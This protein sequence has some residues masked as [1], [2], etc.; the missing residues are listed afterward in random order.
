MPARRLVLY[1]TMRIGAWLPIAFSAGLL[2]ACSLDVGGLQAAP[3]AGGPSGDGGTRADATSTGHPDLPVDGGLRDSGSGADVPGPGAV[4]SDATALPDAVTSQE[5]GLDVSPPPDSDAAPSVDAGTPPA[6]GSAPAGDAAPCGP[7]P[8]PGGPSCVHVPPGWTLVAF[9]SSQ[10]TACPADF[11]AGTTDLVEGPTAAAGACS[12]GACTVTAQPTCASGSVA[13]HYDYTTGTGAGTCSLPASPGTGPLSNSPPGSCG[14]DLYQ[15]SYASFDIAYTAPPASGGACTA[16]GVATG[17]GVTYAAQDR[18]CAA[19]AALA[20]SCG[21]G[22]CS[23]GVA[24]PFKACIMNAG[25]VACPPGPMSARHLV[26]SGATVS[27]SACSTC[28][29]AATCSG[30]VTLYTDPKCKSG[31]FAVPADG[32]CYPIYRQ[33]AS[34]N[35][36]TYDGG[37]PQ[38]VTCQATGGSTAQGVTLTNEATVC[39]AP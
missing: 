26:G 30:A 7:G 3:D 2:A 34:Y 21:A 13:V 29:V 20:A 24:A 8:G 35:S 16:P 31:A 1:L 19:D 33:G 11:T 37:A 17:A 22:G 28:V 25:E 15:G 36:Y 5:G 14:T 32:N 9:A 39:C 10:A 38:D 18:A 23:P 6:D 4:P 12:C 27:C